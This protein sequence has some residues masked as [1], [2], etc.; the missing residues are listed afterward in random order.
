MRFSLRN[1]DV[2]PDVLARYERE[3]AADLEAA[4]QGRN[5]VLPPILPQSHF[6]PQ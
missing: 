2:D 3:K 1:S 6:C 4:A 5:G